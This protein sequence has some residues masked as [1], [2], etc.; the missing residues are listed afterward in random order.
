MDSFTS[1]ERLAFDNF[2]DFVVRMI[3]K[4]GDKIEFTKEELEQGRSN[5]V[6]FDFSALTSSTGRGSMVVEAN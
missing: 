4:Y 5:K 1:E 2:I 6:Y 3:Q